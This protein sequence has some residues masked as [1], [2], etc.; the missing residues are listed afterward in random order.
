M[1]HYTPIN[2]ETEV[3]EAIIGPHAHPALSNGGDAEHVQAASRLDRPANRLSTAAIV[4]VVEGAIARNRLVEVHIKTGCS[5]YN[6]TGL[7]SRFTNGGA[8][9]SAQVTI[10]DD[11]LA[12]HELDAWLDQTR[13]DWEMADPATRGTRV[14]MSSDERKLRGSAHLLNVAH[15]VWRYQHRFPGSNECKFLLH[16]LECSHRAEGYDFYPW[17]AFPN[18]E[19]FG[20]GG[21]HAT[22][23]CRP[24]PHDEGVPGWRV[25][26]SE[27]ESHRVNELRRK[28]CKEFGLMWRKPDGTDIVED[29]YVG[30]TQCVHQSWGFPCFAPKPTEWEEGP[31]APRQ[32]VR[33]S[34]R[35]KPSPTEEQPPKQEQPS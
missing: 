21:A 34:K 30:P 14:P 28:M 13:L 35:Q 25:E 32:R 29:D 18:D 7:L 4:E 19:D 2:I 22:K 9:S 24:F 16:N 12:S 11:S 8:S 1:A 17:P 26:I 31:A 5:T 15:V 6:T 27:L 33:S 20:P 23:G 10:A 3:D